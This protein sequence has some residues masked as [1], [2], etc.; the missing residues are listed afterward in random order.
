M[1]AVLWAAARI[2]QPRHG[3]Y[4]TYSAGNATMPHGHM[5]AIAGST[6]KRVLTGVAFIEQ[7]SERCTAVNA[8]APPPLPMHMAWGNGLTVP[9]DI[10]D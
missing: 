3:A 7:I 1:Q 9:A 6:W 5:A 10:I 8:L 4:L 2:T